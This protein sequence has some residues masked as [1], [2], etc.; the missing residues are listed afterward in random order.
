MFS[1]DLSDYYRDWYRRKR[2]LPPLGPR[3]PPLRPGLFAAVR[4]LNPT[5][6]DAV[7]AA[8]VVPADPGPVRPEDN[9]KKPPADPDPVPMTPAQPAVPEYNEIP[10]QDPT[11]P[12]APVNPGPP[13]D[14]GGGADLGGQP[15][16]A[17]RSRPAPAPAPGGRGPGVTPDP[18][19]PGRQP[20]PPA[21]GEVVPVGPSV[22][23]PLRLVPLPLRIPW[24]LPWPWPR[25]GD[26]D[27]KDHTELDLDD[28]LKLLRNLENGIGPDGRNWSFMTDRQFLDYY[29][30]MQPWLSDVH[31]QLDEIEDP[32]QRELVRG[33]INHIR[34][35]L[36][37]EFNHRFPP[38]QP[39]QPGIPYRP[40]LPSGP[41]R[42]RSPGDHPRPDE[43]RLP[44][45]HPDP[46]TE[47]YRPPAPG[48][49]PGPY[50]P[51]LPGDRPGP[52]NPRPPGDAPEPPRVPDHDTPHPGD[53]L[54]TTTPRETVNTR[55]R[56]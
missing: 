6:F 33:M 24:S 55:F 30:Q 23:V 5:A 32:N 41:E 35:L 20:P 12:P 54:T 37:A 42:P 53:T 52:H 9:S 26:G 18:L 39:H 45:Y 10:L 31:N 4:A 43:P 8:A 27:D 16:P 40:G 25:H 15:V 44:G 11:P 34:A 47:P 7:L 17:P 1:V 22:R 48:D 49:H 29:L 36:D 13:A 38:Q 50:S 14:P 46:P 21:T 19:V 2:G 3:H 28:L 56:R 51:R